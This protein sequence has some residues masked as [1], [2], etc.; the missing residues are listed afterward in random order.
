MNESLATLVLEYCFLIWIFA[1]EVEKSTSLRIMESPST[2]L[3]PEDSSNIKKGSSRRLLHANR[4]LRMSST[5]RAYSS[6]LYSPGDVT[7]FLNLEGI[8]SMS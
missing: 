8:I 4:I 1:G 6:S 7:L 2:A 5:N 3:E